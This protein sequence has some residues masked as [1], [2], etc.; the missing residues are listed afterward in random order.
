MGAGFVQCLIYRYTVRTTS[1]LTNV[2][3]GRRINLTLGSQQPYK[4]LWTFAAD[5]IPSATMKC[6]GPAAQ[7]KLMTF[8]STTQMPR[9]RRRHRTRS[10]SRARSHSAG[11]LQYEHKR[12]RIEYDSPQSKGT[13]RSQDGRKLK[14]AGPLHRPRFLDTKRRA[15]AEVSSARPWDEP[16]AP[17]Q[18]EPS[19]I[20]EQQ[21]TTRTP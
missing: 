5:L 11:S 1:I 9:S 15:R 16:G 17:V 21:P 19:A 12:R 13:Y 3:K 14:D 20:T 18:A 8:N 10:H 4:E 2:L 6:Y 7:T